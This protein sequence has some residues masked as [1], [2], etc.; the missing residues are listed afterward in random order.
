MEA[1]TSKTADNGLG[2]V[3]VV[4]DIIESITDSATEALS[5]NLTE[6]ILQ[7]V[8]NLVESDLKADVTPN[9]QNITQRYTD[10]QLFSDESMIGQ[11]FGLL[12]RLY[13]ILKN[14]V[15]CNFEMKIYEMKPP[16]RYLVCLS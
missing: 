11:L 4:T 13:Y 10:K 2:D 6:S 15:T 3:A 5:P 8:S 7:T 9:S 12:S 16:Y 14:V 1:I